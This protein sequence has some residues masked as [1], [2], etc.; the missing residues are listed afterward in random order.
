METRCR[1]CSKTFESNTIGSKYCPQCNSIEEE[2]YQAVRELVKMNPGISIGLV[3]E[4]TG[5]STRKIINYVRDE[6][7]EYA[8]DAHAFLLCDDCGARIKTGRYC[9]KCKPKHMHQSQQVI[10]VNTKTGN[11][12]GQMFTAGKK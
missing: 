10:A 6:K 4:V 7:L 8:A 5:L 2:K 1:R 12:A 9:A 11:T 3:S